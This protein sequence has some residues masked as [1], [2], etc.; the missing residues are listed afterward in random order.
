MLE[1]GAVKAL[2][3]DLL[4]TQPAIPWSQIAR[5]RDHLARRYFDTAHSILQS[6]VDNDLLELELASRALAESMTDENH[7]GDSR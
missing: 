2:P 4:A 6:T 1:I 5:L 3:A 7:S